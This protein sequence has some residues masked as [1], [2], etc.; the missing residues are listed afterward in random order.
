MNGSCRT[1]I[2]AH[3]EAFPDGRLS[4][5]GG[6]SHADGSFLLTR[7]LDGPASDA[8]ALGRQ[9]RASSPSDAFS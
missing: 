5:T 8:A 2:G 9:P 4:L 6:S 1:P 7:S 3:T